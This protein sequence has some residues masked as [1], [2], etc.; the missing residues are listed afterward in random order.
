VIVYLSLLT[1][2][3]A[4]A[5][6]ISCTGSKDL[7]RARAADLIQNSAEFKQI[8]V[9]SFGTANKETI[10]ERQVDEGQYMN[11]FFKGNSL[12]R[13]LRSQ[14]FI[15]FRYTSQKRVGWVSML[16]T[17]YCWDH[18]V[19]L[20]LTEKG[21][22]ESRGWRQDGNTW[23]IPQA[24]REFIEVT[25]ITKPQGRP[26]AMGEMAEVEYTWKWVPTEF[27]EALQRSVPEYQIDSAKIHEGLARFQLYDDGWRLKSL[28]L[29]R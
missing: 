3:A 5:T 10:C 26:V 21:M 17:H 20:T 6:M 18:N 9:V 12:L 7:S 24:N 11:N 19:H 14:G 29:N 8:S 28:S 2:V 23:Y 1:L 27:G 16:G 4:G 13:F 22:S 15:E 25:G